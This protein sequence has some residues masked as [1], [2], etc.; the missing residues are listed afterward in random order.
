MVKRRQGP[1]GSRLKG[2]H[3]QM[4]SMT[5]TGIHLSISWSIPEENTTGVL[6][7]E[8]AAYRSQ[9]PES[10]RPCGSLRLAEWAQS[11]AE[12]RWGSLGYAWP[13]E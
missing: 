10:Y 13:R 12:V 1:E 5:P 7:S 8:N 4:G 9:E 6:S 11:S 3:L 2:I